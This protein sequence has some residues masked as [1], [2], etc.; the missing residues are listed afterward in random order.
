MNY[1]EF[2]KSKALID[3]PTGF[4]SVRFNEKLF[5]FQ[6]D[7]VSWACRRGRAA[8]FED[9]GL[10]KTPQQL[11]WS[12][13]VLEHTGK[14]VLI[15]APLCVAEQT[16][17]EGGKFGI[18]VVHVREQCE[19]AGIGIYITNYERLHKFDVSEFGAIVL[20][21]SSILKSFEGATR[22][23]IIEL[24]NRTPYKLAC[25]ATPAP[26]DYMELGNH[27]EFLG[28]MS[29]VEM[30][31]M[32]FV[33]DGGETSQWR[34]KGHAESNFWKWL[35][36][37]AVNIRKPSDLGYD[38]DGFKLPPLNMM[39]HVIESESATM[40]GYLFSMPA[41]SL[42]ERRNARRS[43]LDLRVDKIAE[44]ANSNDEPWVIW[45]GLNDESQMLESKINGAVEVTGSQDEAVKESGLRG[46]ADGTHRVIVTKPS[47]A[48]FG[49]NWQHC[50][51]VGYCGVSDSYEDFYQTVRR[52]WRF[53]QNNPVNAH[54]VISHLEGAVLANLK[55]KEI[56]ASKMAD[57]MVKHMAEISST[58]IKGVT[59]D[60]T[61]YKPTKKM[62]IPSWL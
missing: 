44:L 59:H 37:W 20:D 56:D 27:A 28:V 15:L 9:C 29:R 19:V 11:D 14:S 36:S 45:C 62:E 55:R 46:F 13:K 50:R 42:A 1:Q 26:N 24:F 21:E 16:E 58:E 25:T 34:L 49:L 54:V 51:N 23:Q 47:I 60:F 32:F 41:S 43:S 52:C 31:S 48:G 57:E 7:V 22:N 8:L 5:Q 6:R 3:T 12:H 61:E 2:I 4:E 18:N 30:L 53:G 35:C 38:D 10:G 39:E 40:D 17:R 33:H